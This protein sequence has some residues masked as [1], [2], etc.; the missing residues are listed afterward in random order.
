LPVPEWKRE[1]LRQRKERFLR[2]PFI[3]LDVETGQ[4]E[5]ARHEP[6]ISRSLLV[7]RGFAAPAFS[8]R[9]SGAESIRA[10]P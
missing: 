9:H 3:R 1:E 2:A 5:G 4:A 6:E 8:L 7:Q 10:A